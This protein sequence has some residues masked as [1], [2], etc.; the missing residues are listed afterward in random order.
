M[1]CTVDIFG[2]RKAI[3]NR[4]CYSCLLG[5]LTYKCTQLALEQYASKQDHFQS[6]IQKPDHRADNCKMVYSTVSN[7]CYGMLRGQLICIC[8]QAS[9]NSSLKHYSSKWPEYHLK[10]PLRQP[11]TKT[12]HKSYVC[13]SSS[14]GIPLHFSFCQ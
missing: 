7:R 5:D 11:L 9:N 10:G 6:A 4:Q 14:I 1:N 13:L 2:G 3:L 12:M 8:L